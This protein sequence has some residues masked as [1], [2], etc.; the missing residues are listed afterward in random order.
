MFFSVA[1]CWIDSDNV[2]WYG[3]IKRMAI[4]VSIAAHI[5]GVPQDTQAVHGKQ[6]CDFWYIIHF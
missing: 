1:A 3:D 4:Y 6:C 5:G 2:V